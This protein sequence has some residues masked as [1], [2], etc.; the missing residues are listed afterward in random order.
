MIISDMMEVM[1][2]IL[3]KLL[4]EKSPKTIPSF[5]TNIIS[6]NENNFKLLLRLEREV[7]LFCQEI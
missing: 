1:I 4:L 3:F 6:R 5:F 2:N 7:S